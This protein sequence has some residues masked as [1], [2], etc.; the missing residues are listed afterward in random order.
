[1][2]R[3]RAA[4]YQRKRMWLG[5]ICLSLS[6]AVAACGTGGRTAGSREAPDAQ[7]MQDKEGA[8]VLSE[9]TDEQKNWM[10]GLSE[11]QRL[12]DFR[13]LCEGLRENYPYVKQASRQAGADL[14]VLERTY[15]EKVEQC[16]NDDAFFYVLKEF[17]GEF[18]Y[19][20][21]LALWGLRYESELA[22]A[23]EYVKE[24]GQEK[25]YQ[26][27]VDALDNPVS[28]KTYAAMTAYYEEVDRLT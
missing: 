28:R 10:G 6:V 8:Q 5:G 2:R 22:S 23:R 19:T 7:S 24:P 26:P 14:D 17:A 11:D 9:M 20:G 16:A 13:S 25:R 12:A 27:Y 1:M 4:M 18:S 21:H 15:Q 3:K